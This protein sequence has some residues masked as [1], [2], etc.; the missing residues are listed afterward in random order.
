SCDLSFRPQNMTHEAIKFR[1]GTPALH[2]VDK[3]TAP[4]NVTSPV[5]ASG[6]K[7]VQGQ[8]SRSDALRAAVHL[9]A[10]VVA[11]AILLVPQ[12]LQVSDRQVRTRS[13]LPPDWKT[14]LQF[15]LQ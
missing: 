6:I 7:A 10:S 15:K 13:F 3:V 5:P 12:L 4:D 2:G 8:A 1:L 14:A 11:P 9:Q